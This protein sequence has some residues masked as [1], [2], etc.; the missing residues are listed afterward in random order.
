M[1]SRPARLL[2][3]TKTALIT[4]LAITALL[5]GVLQLHGTMATAELIV[6]ATNEGVFECVREGGGCDYH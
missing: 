1:A 6:S 4:L 3:N 2:L 5:H